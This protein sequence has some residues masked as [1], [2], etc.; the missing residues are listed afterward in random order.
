MTA[1]GFGF[2]GGSDENVLKVIMVMVAQF[3][4]YTENHSVVYL[5]VNCM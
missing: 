5:Q 2:L 3:C 4:E 1:N